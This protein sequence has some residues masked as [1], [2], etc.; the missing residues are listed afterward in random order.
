MKYLLT[1]LVVTS[2]TVT[3]MSQEVA[4]TIAEKDLM[5]EGI[6]IDKTTGDFYLSSIFKNK[7]VKV[8]KGKTTDFIQSGAEGFMGGV[9]LHIDE[10]RKVLWAC[11]GN[12]MGNKFRRG[13]HAFDLTTGKL[14]KKVVFP[15]DTVKNFFNDLVIA[16]DGTVY[17][18]DTFGHCIWEWGLSMESPDN[19]DLKPEKLNLVGAVEYPN[20]ITMSPDEKYLFVATSKGLKRFNL[21]DYKVEALSIPDGA[22]TSS[23]LDGI[24]FYENSIVGVQNGY[25]KSADMKIVRYYL[26]DDLDRIL[27][28]EIIDTGNKY[29]AV[30]T[31]L[32][33]HQDILYV[34]AN[35]Q[36]DNLDQENVK[37]ISPDKLTQTF[38]LKY[39]LN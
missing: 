25:D 7:I 2:F 24:E 15:T 26:S 36:L 12:I 39:K 29:F 14:L 20:G 5:P 1:L 19:K 33:I 6:T 9:G 32:V 13:I 11:S 22:L 34:I 35:S 21:N 16:G 4:F 38:I 17:V 18:T 23:G 10:T 3:G 30:P 28:T 37:I 27:K 31:T 8:S